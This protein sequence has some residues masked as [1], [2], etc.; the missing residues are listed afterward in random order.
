MAIRDAFLPEFDHEMSTTRKTLERVPEDK[1]DWKPH[2]SSMAMG[3]LAGH[4]AEMAGFVGATF[5]G[6]SFDFHPA[7]APPSVPTVMKSRQ[8]LLEIFDK[9]VADAR[10]AIAKASDEELHKTWTLLNG[11]KTFF[12]MPRIQVLRSMILNH[13]IH[14][15]GQLSVYLRMNQVPVPSIYGPSGDEGSM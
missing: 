14:H 5:Q 13:I 4:I 12:S 7:G 2:N 6:D 11:G 8:Q 15:R 9:N 10:A 1:V 3:R